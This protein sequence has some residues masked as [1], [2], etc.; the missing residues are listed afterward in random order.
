MLEEEVHRLADPRSG[1]HPEDLHDPVPID[2]RPDGI[3]LLAGTQIDYPLLQFVDPTLDLARLL[4]VTSRDVAADQIVEP[5]EQV[6]GVAHVTTHRP[7]GPAH[8]EGVGTHVEVNQAGHGFDI[9]LRVAQRFE[10][11]LGH[12][13]SDHFVMVE[14]DACGPE[15]ARVGLANIVKQGGQPRYP[16]GGALGN[17]GQGVGQHVLVVVNRILRHCQRRQFGK[18][19]IGQA[20]VHDPLQGRDHMLPH[21]DPVQFVANAFGT[22]DRKPLRHGGR[23]FDRFRIGGETERGGKPEQSEHAKRVVSERDVGIQRC[24]QDGGTEV[25]EPVVRIDDLRLGKQAKCHRIDGEVPPRQVLLEV[26]G[27]FDRGLAAVVT[28]YLAA[29][30]RRLD[31]NA[32]HRAAD[33]AVG[34]AHGDHRGGESRQHF[35]DLVGTGPGRE[36]ELSITSIPSQE[37]V[38]DTAAYEPNVVAG[39]GEL[40]R[41]P[42]GDAVGRQEA[43]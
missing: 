5:A 6:A 23:R 41:D 33:G 19:N 3:D 27:E 24:P 11:G 34:L 35:L 39:L 38:A 42:H 26:V 2:R 28:V 17:H 31:R 16:V 13:R 29:E 40:G 20:R 32:V 9:V 8:L 7:V 15:V 12:P 4:A 37:R 14:R 10:P 36:V 1:R 22:D 43:F 21:D 25:D 30:G 18:E